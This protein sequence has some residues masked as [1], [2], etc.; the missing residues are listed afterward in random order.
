[1]HVYLTDTKEGCIAEY[2][3]EP[4]AV[5]F[6]LAGQQEAVLC[7]CSIS[8]E[9]IE[10]SRYRLEIKAEASLTIPC[11]RCLRPVTCPIE[12][13]DEREILLDEGSNATEEG[14]PLYFVSGGELDV[15]AFLKDELIPEMPAKVLCKEDCK[16]LCPV[17]GADLNNIQ[18][19]CDSFIPDPRMAAIRDLFIEDDQGE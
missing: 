11:S 5:A 12:I 1:M 14:E 3:V 10:E 2:I 6:E 8:V 13:I 19:G 9:C 15:Y 16:G 18:C 17:C 7:S 4:G